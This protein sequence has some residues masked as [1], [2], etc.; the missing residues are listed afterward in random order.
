MSQPRQCR[1]LWFSPH[2]V[3]YPRPGMRPTSPLTYSATHFKLIK[4]PF[5]ISGTNRLNIQYD[6]FRN[7]MFLLFSILK[8]TSRRIKNQLIGCFLGEGLGVGRR[9]S[10]HHKLF[11]T[12]FFPLKTYCVALIEIKLE[13]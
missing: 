7:L 3:Y 12:V 5:Y 11:F 6:G 4:S 2:G 9:L 8:V 10:F 13:S 1:D